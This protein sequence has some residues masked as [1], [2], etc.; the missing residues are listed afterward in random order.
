VDGCGPAHNISD[1]VVA[2]EKVRSVRLTRD[3]PHLWR[4]SGWMCHQVEVPNGLGQLPG[5][6][7]LLLE[8]CGDNHDR[9][10]PPDVAAVAGTGSCGFQMYRISADIAPQFYSTMWNLQA[11]LPYANVSRP[12]CWSYPE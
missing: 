4:R 2:L 12:G 3:R 1:W 7:E 5:P 10:S 11:M 8:N 9:W 6:R